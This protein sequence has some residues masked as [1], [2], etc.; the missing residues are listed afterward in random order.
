MKD[1]G[2]GK[3]NSENIEV[4]HLDPFKFGLAHQRVNNRKLKL[5]QLSYEIKLLFS[6]IHSIKY[7]TDLADFRSGKEEAI[8]LPEACT[9]HVM[10]VAALIPL[11]YLL[12]A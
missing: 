8:Q 10:L 9:A 5:D 1:L 12:P 2:P 7:V 6:V 4:V 11:L 3:R